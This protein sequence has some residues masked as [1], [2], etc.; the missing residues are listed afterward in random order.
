MH[1]YLESVTLHGVGGERNVLQMSHQK[2]GKVPGFF[3]MEAAH[4]FD[5]IWQCQ[6]I[7][8]SCFPQNTFASCVCLENVRGVC[9]V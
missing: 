9:I 2:E 8:T 1:T 6:F 4:S 5:N 3:A 7:G